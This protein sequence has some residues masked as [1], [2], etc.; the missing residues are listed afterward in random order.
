MVWNQNMD[1]G[2]IFLKIL[3]EILEDPT[4]RSHIYKYIYL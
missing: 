4:W 1:S 2:L 3:G